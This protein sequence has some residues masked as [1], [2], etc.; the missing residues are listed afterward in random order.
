[1]YYKI[2][3][4]IYIIGLYKMIGNLFRKMDEIMGKYLVL[5]LN[6]CVVKEMEWRRMVNFNIVKILV[7]V[8]DNN[9]ESIYSLMLIMVRELL[10]VIFVVLKIKVGI[11]NYKVIC[12]FEFWLKIEW[13]IN[14][15]WLIY[16]L[17][18]VNIY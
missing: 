18:V 8:M 14:I 15:I 10:M 17:Y 5:V 11:F 3:I 7:I 2:D 4:I 12:L 6:M 1:M 13:N 16:N 9:R